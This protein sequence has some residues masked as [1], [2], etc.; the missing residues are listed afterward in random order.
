LIPDQLTLSES[1]YRSQQEIFAAN[2]ELSWEQKAPIAIWRGWLS[3]TGEVSK[4][5]LSANYDTTPRFTLCKIATLHPNSIDAGLTNL[6]SKELES[7]AKNLG[8]L[9][10][11]LTK[12]DHLKGKYLPVLDGHMCTYPGY[13]WRLLSN[14]VCLKQESDQVQWFYSALQP[15]VHYIPV[16]NDMSDLVEKIEWAKD[17]DEEAAA[18]SKQA[19]DFAEKNLRFEDVYYYLYLTFHEYAKHEAI[20]FAAL[21]KETQADPHWKCIQYRKRL[22]LQKSFAKFRDRFYTHY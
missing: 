15:F 3:D 19:R 13:Q 10:N 2:K 6:D 11:S 21:K 7:I 18:I 5:K 8:M 20:D 9:K 12:E 16:K 17:H 14:S 4:G 1:W 22:S